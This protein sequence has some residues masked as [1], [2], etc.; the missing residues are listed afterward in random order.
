VPRLGACLLIALLGVAACG[1]HDT[2][3]DANAVVVV[4]DALRAD[5]LGCYGYPRPTSPRIDALAARGT[6][7]TEAVTVSPWTLPAMATAWTGLLPSVHG[8]MDASDMHA[9]IA[10]R[11]HF[12]PTSVVDESRTTLAEVLRDHGLATAAFVAGSYP[13]RVFG[14]AQGFEEF[15]DEGLF[16]PRMQVEALWRWLD[17]TRPRRFFAYLHVMSVHS[18]YHAPAADPRA[19][20]PGEQGATV[21]ALLADER[22]RWEEV[23]FDPDY[24]G[25]IDGTW[26]SL[27]SIRLSRRLPPV[28]DVEHLVA[29]YDQGIRYTDYWIGQLADGLA[30]RGLLDSTV[31]VVTADHGEE[32]GEHGQLEHSHT[33]FEE[34]MRIPL[35][36]VA[37]GAGGVVT[38]QVGLVDLFPTLLDLLAVPHDGPVQGV[39]LRPA[40]DGKPL[41]EREM[42]G[43]A[44][45]VAGLR[46]LRTPAAKY[47]AGPDTEHLFDLRSDPHERHDLCAADAT[48]C[49]PYRQRLAALQAQSAAMLA[50]SG[51][52]RPATAV[53]DA[54]TGARLR[55]LGYH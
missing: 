41:P 11:D 21:R 29:L 27:R 30:A 5:H 40:L 12:R 9:W 4:V 19:M 23:D 34:V 18:P 44:S 7:F 33:F 16:G 39:S 54:E 48:R 15:I 49:A 35:V 1:C 20:P 13:S 43:E 6:R 46:A 36:I 53:I 52:P 51:L 22:R 14:M 31:L 2:L 3:R 10:D 17:A 28:R 24:E 50:R 25:T 26:A 32:F 42:V 37:P 55:A 38:A 8:A 47:I 45:Q